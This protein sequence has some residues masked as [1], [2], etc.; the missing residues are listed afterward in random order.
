MELTPVRNC[1]GYSVYKTE[2]G[3]TVKMKK[4]TGKVEVNDKGVLIVSGGE[5]VQVEGTRGD[6]KIVVKDSSVSLIGTGSG[7][8]RLLLDNCT[9]KQY[10]S[11]W[12]TGSAIYTG[13]AWYRKKNKDDCAEIMIKGDFNGYIGAQQG[14][15]KGWGDDSD[16]HRD[17]IMINGNNKGRINVDTHDKVQIKGEKGSICNTTVYYM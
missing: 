17:H 1:F 3:A 6:D 14:A 15:G 16:A 4:G 13:G 5:K 9:Y 7:K 8:D 10:N 12:G 11:F 2:N